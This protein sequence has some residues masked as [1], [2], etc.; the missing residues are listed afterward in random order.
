MHSETFTKVV[1]ELAVLPEDAH[2][3]VLAFIA[4]WQQNNQPVQLAMPP[5]ARYPLRGEIYT[6]IDPCE[7]ALPADM[8][9]AIGGEQSDDS[10]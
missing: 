9:H 10:D 7:P 3:E 5:S 1:A 6:Y 8:W 4:R 2:L